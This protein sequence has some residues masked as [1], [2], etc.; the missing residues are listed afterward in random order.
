M[1]ML[2]Y[3][4]EI[5]AAGGGAGAIEALAWDVSQVYWGGTLPGY[6]IKMGHTNATQIPN[7]FIEGLQVVKSSFDYQ[8][9]LGFNDIV[10]DEPFEWDGTSN[11]IVEICFG[12]GT[13]SSGAAHGSC[14]TYS[15]PNS[16]LHRQQDDE[17]ACGE[18]TTSSTLG[19][20]ARVRFMMPVNTCLPASGLSVSN[21]TAYGADFSWNA[22]TSDPQ[23]GYNWEVVDGSNNVVVSGNSSETS[24]TVSGLTPLSSY[25]FKVYANCEDGVDE[26]SPISIPFSTIA[27]CLPP[28]NINITSITT[29]SVELSWNASTSNPENGYVW[30]VRLGET[31]VETGISEGLNASV[32]GLTPNTT[33]TFYVRAQCDDVDTSVWAPS[34][35][36]F[37]GYCI[38]TASN[39][40]DYISNFATTLALQNVTNPTTGT[41]GYTDHSSLVIQHYAGGSF[42]FSTTYV[43]GNNGVRIWV[44]WN[45]NLEFEESEIVYQ[46]YSNEATKAG[47]ISIPA[48]TPNGSYRL[49]IRSQWGS[50]TVYPPACG[51]INWGEAEDYTLEV[52]D[53]PPCTPPNNLAI[54]GLTTTSATISWTSSSEPENGFAWTLTDGDDNE[55]AN[56]TTD[57]TVVTIEDLDLE[58]P[59]TFS[60]LSLCSDET[61]SSSVSLQFIL[62]YCTV[63]STSN[64]GS[65]G[66]HISSV[67]LT[68]TE[69]VVNPSTYNS[70][71]YQ[72]FSNISVTQYAG[73]SVSFTITAGSADYPHTKHIWVDWNNDLVFSANELVY[74]NI[75]ENITPTTS[76]SFTIDSNQAPGSY[77]MRIRSKD[78]GNE[79][80]SPCGNESW[81]ETEDYTL[82]VL[83]A[84]PC[85]PPTLSIVSVSS[86]SVTFTWTAP[87]GTPLEYQWYITDE[88]DETVASGTSTE[89]ETV[90]ATG[91]SASSDYTIHIS[92]L[93]EDEEVSPTSIASF[94]TPCPKITEFPYVESFEE[95]SQW[96]GCWIV[97]N[98]PDAMWGL[99]IGSLYGDVPGPHSG[100]YN[101]LLY[102]GGYDYAALYTPILDLTSL[103]ASGAELNFAYANPYF[104]DYDELEVWYKSSEDGDWNM[105]AS[106]G[107]PTAEDW[108]EITL[109]LPD[110]SAD[111]QIA[112]VG[113]ST[114]AETLVL[115]DVIIR[116]IEPSCAAVTDVEVVSTTTDSAIITWTASETTPANGYNWTVYNADN[117]EVAS[118]NAEENV[119][120][121]TGLAANT[122]YTIVVITACD[123]VT[124][125]DPS[126]AVEFTTEHILGCTDETACNY[127]PDAT[128]DDGSCS[129]EPTTWYLDAD[130]D[131][132]GDASE[133]Q[134]ACQ[135]PEGYV[136]N[137]TD[138]DDS[139]ATVWQSATL[140][141][142]ADGDGY[143]AGSETVCYGDNIPEGYAAE[144]LGT[145][146]ND[147]DA[148][149]YQSAELY[150]DADGDGYDAGS[151]T[152]CYGDEIPEG[153][154]AETLG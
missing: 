128:E 80:L 69:T 6:T 53:A 76:G 112:F 46:H 109:T 95:D 90:T 64:L 92:S 68:G 150:I 141:I 147:T 45:N 24:V 65:F 146:C 111:Y 89:V 96:V 115:D 56:G 132:Y 58:V 136:A 66:D 130:G 83:P 13:Y 14:W 93:C 148:A 10:F 25:S 28:S 77:R 94:S 124:F 129:Y 74:M 3:A 62:E 71:G 98:N 59:Y 108:T 137:N 133:A 33:Y 22:S 78:G 34:Y 54:S 5:A 152:V 21:I 140:Y 55:I 38:P 17:N 135:Q 138:C 142:D 119:A 100:E 67:T 39:T 29:T 127:N 121:V 113:Y 85:M 91:L 79:N 4:S 97:D 153:Y 87:N 82:I 123:D 99:G 107:T 106:F 50:T 57:D 42:N 2:Y 23:D 48:G 51:N 32:E 15:S 110:I 154:A 43:S 145:D 70:V 44:D 73:L 117:E 60:V 151:E 63:G 16:V 125:S 61:E 20:K 47:A 81:S 12:V 18:T 36:F 88:N 102:G 104:D 122:T 101:A 149:A 11:I 105:I 35:S 116:A 30:Q 27:S 52:V 8:P 7:A 120:T 143:D 114:F 72:N 86:E 40:S 26:S 131:G 31:V 9:A 37:T 144:T 49:R 139:D 1:Q 75:S 19:S 118:G 103:M 84:P 126:E 41:Y 134:E